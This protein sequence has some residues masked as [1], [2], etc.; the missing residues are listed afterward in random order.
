MKSVDETWELLDQ[1]CQPLPGERV[2]LEATDGRILRQDAVADSDQPPF[3]R[4]AMDGYLVRLDEAQSILLL[5]GE[6]RPGM[7]ARMPEPGCA[8]RVFTGSAVPDQGAAVVMQEETERVENKVKLL[9]KPGSDWIR[10]RG[11]HSRQGDVLVP[12]GARLTP[13]RIALLASAGIARPMV[14]P[15]IRVAHIATGSEIVSCEQAPE[16]G[17]IRDSNSPMLAALLREAGAEV[18]FHR[19][20][21]ESPGALQACIEKASEAGMDLLLVSGG[22]SVG[23][24]DH[25]R[26]AFIRTCFNLLV[27]G[28]NSRPG[29]PL[30][31]AMQNGVPAFGLPGNPLSHFVCF[32]LFVRRALSRLTGGPPPSLVP[33]QVQEA[34]SIRPNPRESWLPGRLL[35]AP[36]AM[37][38]QLLPWSDSSDLTGLAQVQ[39]LLRVPPGGLGENGTFLITGDL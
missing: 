8:L 1:Y 26:E 30:I 10:L 20:V 6:V 18:V 11:A 9:A 22:A 17:Q 39:G 33:V 19:R 28:V 16:E 14:S 32:H 3:S 7:T 29:K 23:D 36:P 25:T 12:A 35:W 21:D 2:G 27:A 13:G 38:V 4:S 34:H 31:V 24:H 5:A 37:M 15:F